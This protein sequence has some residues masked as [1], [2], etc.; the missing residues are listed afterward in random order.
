M[1]QDEKITMVEMNVRKYLFIDKVFE[2]T[3]LPYLL[4]GSLIRYYRS[5]NSYLFS[6]EGGSISGEAAGLAGSSG[7]HAGSSAGMGSS[8]VLPGLISGGLSGG[9]ISSGLT[10]FL[11]AIKGF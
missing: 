5:L 11:L 2:S 10:F 4:S 7:Y 8:G 1:L 3:K 9:G 6:L